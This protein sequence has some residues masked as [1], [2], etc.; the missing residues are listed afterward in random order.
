MPKRV[1][2]ILKCPT[3]GEEVKNLDASSAVAI[4]ML[5]TA[6]DGGESLTKPKD[7]RKGMVGN[8]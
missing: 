1:L 6:L 4:A 5:L 3:R 2:R 8:D 7:F